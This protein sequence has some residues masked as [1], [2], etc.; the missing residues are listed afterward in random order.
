MSNNSPTT[1]Q[2]L[3]SITGALYFI[4]SLLSGK[5]KER[6]VLGMLFGTALLIASKVFETFLLT[7]TVA[8]LTGHEW[9]FYVIT[10]L[11]VMY[12]PLII[13]NMFTF[14]KRSDTANAAFDL[15]KQAEKSGV[16]KKT[17]GDLYI[18]ATEMVL[19]KHNVDKKEEVLAKPTTPPQPTTTQKP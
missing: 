11:F 1:Q 16:S 7:V 8:K 13:R 12:I 3:E 19:E 9:Y 5:Y 18:L 6:T 14:G 4:V 15:I 17:I 10:G 2:G